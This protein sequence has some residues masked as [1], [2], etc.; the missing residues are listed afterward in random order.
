[1]NALKSV[2]LTIVAV[3]ALFIGG[4]LVTSSH[5]MV[6]MSSVVGLWLLDGDGDVARDSSENGHDGTI[7]GGPNSINGR[8]GKALEFDGA[9]DFIDCGNDA[10]LNL[11]TF[12]VMFWASMPATQ[13]WNH[14]VS[15]GSH[16]GSGTPGSVNWGVMVYSAEQM[17]LYEIYEDI[18][19]SGISADISLGDWHHVVATYDGGQDRME[20]LIDGVSKG[21][22][23]GATVEL[24]ASRHFRIGGISTSGAVPE[25]FFSGSIDEVAYFDEVLSLEDI[26]NIMNN[27][28]T[29]VLNITAVSP[30][31]KA[32]TTWA[33]LKAK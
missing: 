23:D 6:D 30:G 28:L 11:D 33:E 1:M 7:N 21:T 12:T 27:G 18:A 32:A 2:N 20:F 24:D 10:A 25:N 16:V 22:A 13:G 15:K 4:V 3:V 31:G 26:Q 5:A 14:I 9:D 8:F 19:W 17:F 29:D